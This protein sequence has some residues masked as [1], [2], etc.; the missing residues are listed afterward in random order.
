LSYFEEDIPDLIN[1]FFDYLEED[2]KHHPIIKCKICRLKAPA[3]STRSNI[4]EMCFDNDF[5]DWNARQSS[6]D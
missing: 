2:G 1:T 3:A 5:W 6:S 4:C